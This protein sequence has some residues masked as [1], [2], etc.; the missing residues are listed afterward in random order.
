MSGENAKQMG[1]SSVD[2]PDW[3]LAE[4]LAE[5]NL[6]VIASSKLNQWAIDHI[7]CQLDSLR[8]TVSQT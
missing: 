6:G 1:C 5:P 7:P 8:Q 3:L 4:L 2:V